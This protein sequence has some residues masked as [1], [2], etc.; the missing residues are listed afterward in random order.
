MKKSLSLLL[1][2]LF[3]GVFVLAGCSGEEE[4]NG[5][6]GDGKLKIVAA[7]N[8]TSP[9]NP[10]QIGM[11]A[12]K[13]SAESSDANIEVEVH[14]GT[15]GT[16]ESE[17]VEKLKLGAADVV[18][19]SP[20]FMSGT[21]IKPIDLFALPYVFDSYDHW[22]SVVD[23]EVGEEMA[24]IVKEE[25]N[26]DFKLLGYWSAGVR[27]YYGKKPLESMDDLKGLK[28]RTQTS[29]AVANYWEQTGAVPTSVAWGELYQGLQQG[30]VDASENSYPYFV[31]ENHHKTDNGKYVT[32]T[33]HDYT[34]RFLLINGKKFE[35]YSEEQKQAI[36]E[37]AEASVE[38]EREAV[39]AQEE[40]YKQQA[41]ED[42]AEVNEIDRQPFID[43]AEPILQERAEE[44][45]A[46]DLLEKINDMK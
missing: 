40:E 11:E 6:S 24:E 43:L 35:N 18:L 46:T 10:Y 29:G 45:G 22:E 17:L 14:A 44:I 2:M 21:G 26:N 4:A 8:Q 16:S 3:A 12:F 15:L 7:H 36:L 32:E 1:F 19:V 34:T 39:Y 30:V 42:G 38:K 33:A 23:G 37:A 20:G 27:H 25:S 13:E 31:Q 28:F 9:E 5:E 41:I